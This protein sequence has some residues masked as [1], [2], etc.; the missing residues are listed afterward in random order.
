MPIAGD[1]TGLYPPAE[2]LQFLD[3]TPTWLLRQQ[4][5]YFFCMHAI[6]SRDMTAAKIWLPKL[7]GPTA[8]AWHRQVC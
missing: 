2:L 1:L 6:L 5:A 4:S 8:I 7:S 3:V